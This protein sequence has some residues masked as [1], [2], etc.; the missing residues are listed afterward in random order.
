MAPR[1][2]EWTRGLRQIEGDGGEW[3]GGGE[4]GH[5]GSIGHGLEEATG[6]HEGVFAG[7]GAGEEHG[8]SGGRGA[9]HGGGGWGEG[10]VVVALI[11]GYKN[12][13]VLSTSLHLLH[14]NKS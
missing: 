3:G 1:E 10:M 7:G 14:Q 6:G 11:G 9:G 4:G 8:G 12:G 5:G 2:L 13:L